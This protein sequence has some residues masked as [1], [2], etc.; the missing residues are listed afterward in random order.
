[1]AK[2]DVRCPVCSEW[3]NVE[4]PDN[5]VEKSTKGLLTINIT[6]G[7][8]CEHSFIVYVDKNLIVRD[9]FVADFKI[10]I[11]EEPLTDKAENGA[12]PA[13]Y[14]FKLDLIKLNIPRGLMVHVFK[15][16]FLK[17]KILIICD[18]EF[19]FPHI[20]NFFTHV[21]KKYFEM[22]LSI[23]SNKDYKKNK[24]NYKKHLIFMNREIIRDKFGLITSKRLEIEKSIIDK[25]FTEKDI[26]PS[27]IILR[28]EIKKAYDFSR[29]IKSF[30]DISI[31][32]NLTSKMILNHLT[33]ECDEKITMSYL[34]FLMDIAKYYFEADIPEIDGSTSLLG[35]L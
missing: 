33:K 24:K 5:A 19:L 16:I 11:P 34:L 1:M 20:N 26:E 12:V 21:I 15:S 10:E 23:I 8:I 32:T 6:A 27:L 25:F 31:G 4:I 7:M 17:K 29:I 30:L 2:I 22:D 14:S 28:N 9:C 13:K 18:Q 3:K 35:S